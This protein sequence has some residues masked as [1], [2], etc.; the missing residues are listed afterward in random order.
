MRVQNDKVK[1]NVFEAVR[2]PVE[3]DACFMIETVE[4][5]VSCHSG[6]TDPLET[7]LVR[8][9]SKELGEEVK[10]YVRWMDSFQ[11]NRRK[12]YEPLREISQMSMPSFKQPPKME[13]KP[14][15]SH[16]RYAYLGEASTLLVIISASLIAT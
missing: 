9:E 15:P 12:Y 13:Q 1:F 4:T 16:L 8:S 5:I 14:L 7:S 11:P 2:H 3:S 10:K 6:P